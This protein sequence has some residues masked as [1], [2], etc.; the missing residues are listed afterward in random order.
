MSKLDFHRLEADDLLEIKAQDSQLLVLGA[1]AEVDPESAALLA[2]QP[3]SWTAW[4]GGRIVAC[5]GVSE[6]FPGKHGVGWALLSASMGVHH[7]AITRFIRSRIAQMDLPRIEV[8]A[9]AAD[10]EFLFQFSHE[11]EPFALVAASMTEPTAE[12]RWAKALGFEPVH[13]LRWFG[14]ASETYM[15]FERIVPARAQL[16]E[17]A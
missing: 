13:V 1:A 14:A 7:L 11:W 16:R 15:L 12:C 17:A 8:L 3:E 6:T 4:Y 5:F 9:R 10:V 2:D